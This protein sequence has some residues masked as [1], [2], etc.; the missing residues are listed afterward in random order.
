MILRFFT[1]M[2]ILAIYISVTNI[3]PSN[4][5]VIYRNNFPIISYCS[6]YNVY[7]CY[8]N[9]NLITY[10]YVPESKYDFQV[11]LSEEKICKQQF[12]STIFLLCLMQPFMSSRYRHSL[13]PITK[14][15]A[16]N[17]KT[18]L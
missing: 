2:D 13:F 1:S 16:V 10:L 17:D 6:F 15:M 8:F 9:L 12:D 7:S 14:N 18:S 4:D 11:Q 5:I 3:H